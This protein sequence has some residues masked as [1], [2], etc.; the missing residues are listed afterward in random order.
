[1]RSVCAQSGL[2]VRA[3]A[4]ASEPE[5]GSVSAKA[6]IISPLASWGR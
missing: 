5:P 2:L 1:M 6:P 4:S 3:V